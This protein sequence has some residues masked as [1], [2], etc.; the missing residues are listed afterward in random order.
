MGMGTVAAAQVS[1]WCGGV[2]G[3]VVCGGVMG[4]VVCGGVMGG[5]WL[6]S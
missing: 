6:H 5:V 2:V 3:G 4:G 1:G